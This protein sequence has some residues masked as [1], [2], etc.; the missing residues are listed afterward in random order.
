MDP[1]LID[2]KASTTLNDGVYLRMRL[3]IRLPILLTLSDRVVKRLVGEQT[4][5]KIV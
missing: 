3:L 2:L 5:R 4:S 1:N